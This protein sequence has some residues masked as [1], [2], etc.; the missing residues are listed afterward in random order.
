MS[1]PPEC[2]PTIAS[3]DASMLVST[4]QWQAVH[5][6]RIR[7][8][9]RHY[10][11]TWSRPFLA[12]L[13]DHMPEFTVSTDTTFFEA[14]CAPG[15]FMVYFH[16]VFG[17]QVAGLELTAPGVDQTRTLLQANHIDGHLYQGDLLQVVPDRQMDVV[18]S[19]G[20]VEHFDDP[21]PCY[22]A[23]C[24]WLHPGGAMIVTVP[25][26]SGLAGRLMSARDPKL[27]R[28]HRIYG[29]TD[30][31]DHCRTVGLQVRFSGWVGVA[32]LPKPFWPDVHWRRLANLPARWFNRSANKLSRLLRHSI[33]LPGI[34]PYA[35][36]VAIKPNPSTPDNDQVQTAP[37]DPAPQ[38]E[39]PRP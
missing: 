38:N 11:H 6:R 1:G 21:I 5:E 19:F 13:T 26:L 34:V 27:Y 35:G 3:D 37:G 14:G 12:E 28:A 16:Q 7:R 29:P 33:K 9:L 30:L 10:R 32:R 18:A 20:L 4:E 17:W 39:R 24:R 25:N 15:R 8:G 23:L 2:E 36:C 22:R 31:A